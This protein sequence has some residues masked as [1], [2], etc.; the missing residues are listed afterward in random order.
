[1]RVRNVFIFSFLFILL[2]AGWSFAGSEL[3]TL[4]PR[5]DVKLKVLVIEPEKPSAVLVLYAGGIGTLDLSSTFGIPNIGKY[6]QN[7][8]VRVR[9]KF[10]ESGFVVALPDVVSDREGYSAVHRM[11]EDHSKEIH[12]VVS[13]LKKRYSLPVWIAG[14]SLSS[15]TVANAA[16]TQGDQI[17]GAIFSSSIVK[18]DPKWKI[19]EKYPA[20][21]V[22]MELSSI[23]VPV[24]I[25]AHKE[26]GCYLT[27]P[28]GAELIKNGLTSAP[29][30]EVKY[31]TGGS[32][33]VSQP[34]DPLSQHGFLGI[35]DQVVA[36][37]IAFVRAI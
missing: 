31:Y 32:T 8:L 4:Q 25:S 5:P 22:N 30:V 33:P 24:L 9:E 27:P 14:T 12:D 21:V 35:E 29:K 18:S 26:D 34:C 11:S 37:M 2:S 17:K 28:E 7:F 10:V 20:G 16:I 1:M 15:F 6:K 36:D 19:Y 23:K 3:I 13:Y